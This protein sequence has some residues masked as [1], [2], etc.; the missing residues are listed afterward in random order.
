MNEGSALLHNMSAVPSSVVRY[1]GLNSLSSSLNQPRYWASPPAPDVFGTAVQF[2]IPRGVSCK[3]ARGLLECLGREPGARPEAE[4]S[5]LID[6]RARELALPDGCVVVPFRTDHREIWT[7]LLSVLAVL[8]KCSASVWLRAK[9]PSISAAL[10]KKNASLLVPPTFAAKLP[11]Q[12][13]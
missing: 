9:T 13:T 6:T 12:K 4:L 3:T 7:D 10:K 5:R 8:A 1:T 2:V 11:E